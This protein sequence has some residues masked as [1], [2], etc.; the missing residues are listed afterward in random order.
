M[1]TSIFKKSKPINFIIVFFITLLAFVT[2][3]LKLVIEPV[4]AGYIFK[5]IALFLFCYGSVLLINFIVSKHSLTKKNSYEILLFSLFLLVIPQTTADP[6]IIFSNF[7][8][9][10]SF[11]RVI[12]LRSMITPE[13]KIFDSA[14]WIA[15]AALFY[16]WAILFFIIIF[17]ALLLYSDNKFKHWLIP[18]F[19]MATVFVIAISIS[20]IYNNNFLGVFKSLPEVSYDFSKYNTPQ[21]IIA[22]TML[23]SF[24]VWSSLF[25]IRSIKSK[26]KAFRPAFK[27]VFLAIVVGFIAVILAPNKD[28]SEFLFMFAPL[29]II[30]T[31]YIETIQDKWFRELFLLTLIITPFVILF[32]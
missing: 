13:K 24:G 26:K 18:F 4:N 19:G 9:L 17:A 30:I 2:A 16:F 14:L 5:Q 31:N 20:I 15:I 29:A 21:F 25:Y 11:R 22:I 27:I 3:K 8:I 12:S 1:I 23:L 28:G 7:F 6:N 10:L 32:L